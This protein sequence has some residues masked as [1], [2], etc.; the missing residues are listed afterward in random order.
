MRGLQR[1]AN[2]RQRRD[3]DRYFF[4]RDPF[5]RGRSLFNFPE[6]PAPPPRRVHVEPPSDEPSG[7][8]YTSSAD[9]D[10]Q[11]F[12][13]AS[14]YVVVMGDTMA[15]QLSQGLADGFVTERPEVAIINN[16]EFD[17]ADIFADLAAVQKTFSHFIRLVPRN[18]LLLGNGDDPNLAPLLDVN[19]CPVKRFGL[20]EENSVCATNVRLGPTASE[21][22]L[23]SAKFH[24][25]LA[26]EFNV[27]NA[28]AV[29][30][31]AMLVV[32]YMLGFGFFLLQ[33]VGPKTP[34]VAALPLAIGTL[35]LLPVMPDIDRRRAG[36]ASAVLLALALGI[37]LWI[38][39]DPLASSIA[40]YSTDH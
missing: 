39:L 26:G 33:A 20:G 8:V 2:P 6:R 14:E 1:R 10:Q 40:A 23:P 22:E 25:N 5:G 17:H 13:G 35:V 27:R 28:L 31:A 36:I 19:F 12:L 15:E 21:F 3:D 9:A 32:G 38:L 4:L 11:R 7:S 30:A 29:V 16:V 18:G 24:L 37:A 34:M